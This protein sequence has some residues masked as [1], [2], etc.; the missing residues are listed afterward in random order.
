MINP[1]LRS[2]G[3]KM[4]QTLSLG[5]EADI[6]LVDCLE[7]LRDEPEV[8]AIGLYVETVRR[9]R[10]FIDA[11]RETVKTKP[12]VA[13]Y[14]GGTEAGS[15]S[16]LSH[17]GA[18]SGPD[19]VY[20]GLFRQAGVI[21]SDD[22]DQMLDIL[23]ALSFQPLPPG[24]RMA[25]ISNSGGP[26]TSLAYHV[27]KVG[28]SVPEFSAALSDRLDKVTGRLASVRNPIDLTFE[29]D[30][31][32]FRRLLEMVFESDEVDGAFLYGIFGTEFMASLEKRFPDLASI[33]EIM[34][35]NYAEFLNNLTAVSRS[36]GKPLIVMSFLGAGSPS[37]LPLIE[38][39]VPVFPSASR[40]ARA[41][42]ALFD[43][44]L[45]RGAR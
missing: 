12:V 7:Y 21:R 6:D 42:R 16:S 23:W 40:S 44:R 34:E 25:V 17:T 24:R 20:D 10:E 11:A 41:M 37:M 30:V 32:L 14:V 15:R 13:I 18:L 8:T 5:N 2:Q 31:S 19:E 27:E 26:G 36:H 43:Y 33:K 38:N 28:L 3:M 35:A 39:D 4:W 45:I 9:P 22:L 29:T 1:M